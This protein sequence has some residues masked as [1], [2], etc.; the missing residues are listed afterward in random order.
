VGEAACPARERR[1]AEVGRVG[2]LKRWSEWS[3]DEDG[4]G[5]REVAQE[6]SMER[7]GLGDE[8]FGW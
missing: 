7:R 8:A 2:E 5:G 1:R 3:S 6:S 4:R